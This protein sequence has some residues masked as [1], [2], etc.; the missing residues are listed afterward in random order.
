LRNRLLL[1]GESQHTCSLQSLYIDP[2]TGSRVTLSHHNGHGTG[3]PKAQLLLFADGIV[4]KTDWKADNL[5]GHHQAEGFA[6]MDV[7]NPAAVAGASYGH[8]TDNGDTIH[9]QWNIGGG[10]DLARKGNTLEGKDAPNGDART[11]PLNGCPLNVWAEFRDSG[12]EFHLKDQRASQ[13]H[14]PQQ[15]VPFAMLEI[16]FHRE[17]API[18]AGS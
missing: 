10:T 11:V 8:W 3:C 2:T 15:C 6:T 9:I 4:A 12:E 1:Q 7:A 17:S 5:A 14:A 18:L 16:E 13:Q